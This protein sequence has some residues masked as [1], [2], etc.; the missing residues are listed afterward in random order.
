M[1]TAST[2]EQIFSQRALPPELE[3][4]Y[5]PILSDLVEVELQLQNELQSRYP[6]VDQ[7]IKHAFLLG[8]KRLRPALVLLS[9]QTLGKISSQHHLLATVVE[10][11][12][13]ATLIHDDIIDLAEV[14]RHLKTVNKQWDTESSVL[15]GDFLFSHAFYLASTLPSNQAC[16]IIGKTTNK[17]CEGE[18]RQKGNQGNF[19][20][21]EEEYFSIVGAK[22]AEL[23]ACCCRLGATFSSAT[24]DE[25]DHLANFGYSLGVA[26]Q[27]ADDLLDI[28]GTEDRVGKSLGT[29]IQT[30]KL[31]LPTIHLLGNIAPDKRSSVLSLIREGK[32]DPLRQHMEEAGSIDYTK[33]VAQKFSEQ[34]LA[35]LATLKEKLS[36]K[37]PTNGNSLTEDSPSQ[38]ALSQ[39]ELLTHYMLRRSQ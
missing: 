31:T 18:L 26:F 38:Q 32:I 7:L 5:Q 2:A 9:A 3:L 12:H 21:T 39:L 8:G 16:Q 25:K 24:D 22:T 6:Y 28:V 35:E 23:C 34:G 15:L 1:K 4:L 33:R 30:Q 36:A 37:R 17:I 13:T 20:L 10:M 27:I 14:R 29:D 11:I 19:D